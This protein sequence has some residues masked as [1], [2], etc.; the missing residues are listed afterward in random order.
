[1]KF[2]WQKIYDSSY[3]KT[4]RAQV[5]GGWIVQHREVDDNGAE[6]MSMV[7][8]PDPAHTWEI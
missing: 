4:Y 8:I 3:S 6:C 5:F 1:M 7:F 2:Q